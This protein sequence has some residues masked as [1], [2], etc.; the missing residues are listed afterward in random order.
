MNN[1]ET[2][3]PRSYRPAG[4]AKHSMYERCTVLVGESLCGG[5]LDYV[6]DR[7]GNLIGHCPKCEQRKRHAELRRRFPHLAALEDATPMVAP[8]L[9]FC[10]KCKGN[11]VPSLRSRRCVHC[12]ARLLRRAQKRWYRQHIGATLSHACLHCDTRLKG[13]RRVCDNCQH[14]TVR[15]HYRSNGR[16]PTAAMDTNQRAVHG[17]KIRAALAKR[18]RMQPGGQAA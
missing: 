2:P 15:H 1:H 18:H 17:L 9:P 3:S 13:K 11:R 7:I 16:T 4:D 12:R 8:L 10:R 6:C 14:K 5:I